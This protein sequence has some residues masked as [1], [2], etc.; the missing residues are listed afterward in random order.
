MV[1]FRQRLPV[2]S[3]GIGYFPGEPFRE[4]GKLAMCRDSPSLLTSQTMQVLSCS[5]VARSKVRVFGEGRALR[6][7]FY[8]DLFR[9]RTAALFVMYANVQGVAQQPS[10]ERGATVR[11]DHILSHAFSLS[12]QWRDSPRPYLQRAAV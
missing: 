4:W 9:E 8:R 11:H 6:C 5:A 10:T 7:A 3:N 1:A 2:A 12:R